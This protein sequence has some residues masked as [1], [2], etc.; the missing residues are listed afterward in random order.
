MHQLVIVSVA[1][2]I[3]VMSV[4]FDGVTTDAEI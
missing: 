2:F 3:V 4:M 1:C